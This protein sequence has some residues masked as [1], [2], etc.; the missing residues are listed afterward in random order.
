M[1]TNIYVPN[2]YRNWV[3]F[4]SRKNKNASRIQYVKDTLRSLGMVLVLVAAYA[5]C[6]YLDYAC[7]L[8]Q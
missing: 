3:E 6:G 8:F 2:G 1:T 4:Y 5:V 7:G